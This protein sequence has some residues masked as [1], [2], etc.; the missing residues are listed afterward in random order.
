MRELYTFARIL[1]LQKLYWH[2]KGEL[3]QEKTATL[4]VC[5]LIGMLEKVYML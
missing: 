3:V 2:N 1:S 4:Q 5:L